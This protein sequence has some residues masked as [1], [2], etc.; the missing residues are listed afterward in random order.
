M[1]A[2][3][4]DLAGNADSSPAAASTK[5]IPGLGGGADGG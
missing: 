2:R 4:T 5:V 3:A 1:S